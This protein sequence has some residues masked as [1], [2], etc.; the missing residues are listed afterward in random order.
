MA[1]RLTRLAGLIAGRK[2]AAVRKEWNAHLFGE[3]GRD[4]S[5]A[6]KLRAALGFTCAALRYRCQDAADLAWQPADAVLKS[7]LLSSL[8]ILAATLTITALFLCRGGL[9]GLADHLDAVGVV[10]GTAYWLIHAGREC[11]GIELAQR[12][13]ERGRK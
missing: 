11:R 6:R 2:R 4:L 13:P 3:T 5:P 7:R 12:K 8:F 10:T 9:Y 1:G